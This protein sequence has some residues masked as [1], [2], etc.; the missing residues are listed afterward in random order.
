MEFMAKTGKSLKELIQDVY[1]IVGPFDFSRDDLHLT[2]AKKHAI[3]Q[4]CADGHITKIGDMD[5]VKY[6]NIDGHKYFLPGDRWVMIRPSGTEPVLRV[7]AQ[8]PDMDQVKDTLRLT[9]DTLNQI[10]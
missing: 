6:E 8:A 9:H 3:V 7:Y 5:V 1:E 2:E 4:H 10:G